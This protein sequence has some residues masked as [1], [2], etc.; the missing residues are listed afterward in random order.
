M[1]LRDIPSVDELLNRPSLAAL[2]AEA[3]RPY[4]AVRIREVLEEARRQLRS[5]D[6]PPGLSGAEGASADEPLAD[7][8]QRIARR[9]QEGLAPSLRA[10]INATGVIL[11]TN[12]GRAP[13][14]AEAAER[15]SEAAASYTNLEYDL[16]AGRRGRRDV[17]AARLLRQLLGAPAMVVNNNAAAVLLVLNTLA[18]GGEVVVSRG[19]LI[20]IGGSFRIPEIMAQSGALLREVGATNKTRIADY[21]AA[22]T[23]ETALLLRVHTSNFK[24]VGFTEQASLSELVELGRRHHLPVMD[25]IGSGA[26]IDL[27]RYGLPEE[28][29]APASLS[30]GADLVCASADKLLGGCQGGVIL[31]RQD[32]IAR[33]RRGPLYRALRVGKLTLIV[34][35]TTLRLYLD[36]DTLMEANPTLR[37]IAEPPE[38]CAR[39]A[40]RIARAIRQSAPHADVVVAT[41][42]AQI[43]SGS[44][45]GESLPTKVVSVRI[46]GLA[47]DELAR[48]LRLSEPPIFTRIRDDRVV[49]DAKTVLHGEA[50]AIGEAF[51]HLT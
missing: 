6:R 21:E 19:E 50:A 28:P 39:R 16:E 24:M 26:L 14:S 11:H 51:R 37:M 1:N 12:L 42:R 22:I 15:V 20:E 35:E 45:P 44:A 17:H 49:I 40:V 8:E 41:S 2:V 36:P 34:L 30:A 13:L 25:D 7:L 47:A 31:G 43:G 33:L 4:V 27:S 29:T 46:P 9:V 23:E 5:G 32:L 3:G 18:E 10:V 38:V 48:R